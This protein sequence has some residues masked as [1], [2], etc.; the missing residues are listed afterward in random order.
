MTDVI[1]DY[2]KTGEAQLPKL[3][4]G[5]RWGEPPA[6]V[7]GERKGRMQQAVEILKAHPGKWAVVSEYSRKQSAQ[8]VASA[9]RRS[10][11]PA[12]AD[13]RFESVCARLG[14]DVWSVY[15]R[16]VGERS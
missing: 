10:S 8:A 13:G 12:F 7:L 2:T 11:N 6:Y 16:Y 3:P 15:A 1:A 4:E 9:I 14:S 5:M